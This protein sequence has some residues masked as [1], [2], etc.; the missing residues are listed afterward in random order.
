MSD[1]DN[2]LFHDKPLKISDPKLL[3]TMGSNW[4]LVSIALKCKPFLEILVS[5]WYFLWLSLI[6]IVLDYR[7]TG[8]TKAIAQLAVGNDVPSRNAWRTGEYTAD[9][10]IFDMLQFICF[11]FPHF[12]K[13]WL[14]DKP[15]IWSPL[16]SYQACGLVKN[17]ALMVYITVG[18]AAYP[19]LEFL[20]EW[21]TENFEVRNLY[22]FGRLNFLYDHWSQGMPFGL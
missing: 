7:E 16:L 3:S 12:A 1:Y 20:E 15:H 5:C 13:C 22:I 9:E 6:E 8:Q 14:F 4:F 11:F 17:L 21:G 19:I 18:S 10:R 2:R